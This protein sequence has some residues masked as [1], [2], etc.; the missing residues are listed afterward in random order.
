[1]YV[2]GTPNEI[3][4]TFDVELFPDALDAT[5]WSARYN[6]VDQSILGAEA[7]GFDV[8]LEV[9]DAAADPGSD[10]V[11]YDDTAMDLRSRFGGQ[12]SVSFTDF[13]LT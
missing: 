12:S 6:N 7:S 5:Q 13:P 2:A 3:R 10:V 8:V 1:M 4:V 11:A 9:T